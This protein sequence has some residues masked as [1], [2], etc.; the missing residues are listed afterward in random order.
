MGQAERGKGRMAEECGGPQSDLRRQRMLGDQLSLGRLRNFASA[1]ACLE[2]CL[3]RDAWSVWSPCVQA[4]PSYRS[5][6]ESTV[7][8]TKVTPFPYLY[9]LCASAGPNLSMNTL[10]RSLEILFVVCFM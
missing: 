2:I 9:A 5:A 10:W 8:S 4:M 3:H 6:L 7:Q 1:N